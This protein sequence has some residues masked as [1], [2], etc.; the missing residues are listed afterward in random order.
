ML[1]DF[2]HLYRYSDYLEATS[3]EHAEKLVGGYTEIMPGR[4]TISHHRHPYDSIRH[5]MKGKCSSTMDILAA[6]V[7]TAAIMILVSLIIVRICKTKNVF[8]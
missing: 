7:I 3:G 8:K 4:P 2:D 6:N 1:E 5:S